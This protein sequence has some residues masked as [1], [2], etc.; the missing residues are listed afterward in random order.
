MKKS[1]LLIYFLH[2]CF[3]ADSQ[4]FI[5]FEKVEKH[6]FELHNTYRDS[7]AQR[8]ISDG[9]KKAADAQVDYLAKEQLCQ[10][11][12]TTFLHVNPEDRFKKYN[13]ETV[14]IIDFYDQSK[15]TEK[16]KYSY[17]GE[18]IT[19]A[20]NHSFQVDSLLEKNIS[21]YIINNFVKSKPHFHIMKNAGMVDKFSYSGYFSVREKVVEYDELSNTVY[22]DIYCVAI[23]GSEYRYDV[24]ALYQTE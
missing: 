5:D 9:C 6:C 2:N 11:E 20:W 12:N 3:N 8:T 14:K 1:L 24:S 13:T 17:D 21:K 22:L 7:N 16:P 23:F 4:F 15:Y 19:C 18:I 10:H